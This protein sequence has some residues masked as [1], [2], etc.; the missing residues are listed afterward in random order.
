MKRKNKKNLKY[1]RSHDQKA[2]L[3][4]KR[5][6]VL[7]MFRSKYFQNEKW[8][9]KIWNK[10]SSTYIHFTNEKEKNLSILTFCE[11]CSSAKLAKKIVF[12]KID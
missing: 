3:D 8:K 7:F 11:S 4:K 1:F 9:Y 12:M 5:K 2:K 10:I 6:I